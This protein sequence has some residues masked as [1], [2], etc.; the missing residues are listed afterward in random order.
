MTLEGAKTNE[1]SNHADCLSV[2][3]HTSS[4]AP[5][6]YLMTNSGHYYHGSEKPHGARTERGVPHTFSNTP[7]KGRIPSKPNK[8]KG[9]EG[10]IRTSPE[11]TNSCK[12]YRISRRN[13]GASH[14]T[15]GLGWKL[16]LRHTSFLE[17][18]FK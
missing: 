11:K 6:I 13:N 7:P 3:T 4:A 1:T 5:S 2:S 17:K 10:V 9:L 8:R 12:T 18:E 16:G 15:C 14:S